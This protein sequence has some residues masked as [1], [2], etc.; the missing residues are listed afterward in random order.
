[1]IRAAIIALLAALPAA[2]DPA[3]DARDAASN[4]LAAAESLAA[5]ERRADRV[6]AL[7]ETVQAYEDG[8]SALRTAILA[9]RTRETALR[10]ELDARDDQLSRILAVLASLQSAPET[11]LLLHPSG[12]LDTARAGMVAADVAPALQGE[13]AELKTLLEELQT[14]TAIRTGAADQ[15]SDALSGIEAARKALTQAISDR[16]PLPVPVA[17]DDAAMIAL[18]EAAETLGAFAANLGPGDAPPT[19]FSAAKGTLALPVSGRLL[20]SAGEADAAGVARPGWLLATPPRALVTAPRAS[21]VRYAG[22]LLD[23]G[24]V[25]ILE[26]ESGYL[27]VLGGLGEMLVTRGM[28]VGTGEAVG[29][30]P[31]FDANPTE[32]LAK[33]GDGSGQEASETLYIEVREAETPV[34]PADWFWTG[35]QG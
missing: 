25:I 13:V 14:L 1:M 15:L 4:L 32:L 27:L 21:T 10:A 31:G 29:M 26:P 17:E 33:I 2:A 16:T 20:R 9:A 23:Y 8:L 18:V 5:A 3:Q 35:R 7:T 19:G 22:P 30:M 34:D 6:A 28:I 12:P 24:N 11:F